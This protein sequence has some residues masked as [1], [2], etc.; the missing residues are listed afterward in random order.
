MNVY[1]FDDTIYD[2]DSTV[3]FYR[4]ALRRHPGLLRYL[5][6]QLWGILRYKLGCGTKERM[7]EAFYAFLRGIP[8]IDEEIRAFWEIHRGNIKLWYLAQKR[9]DDLIIS[10]SPAFLLRPICRELGVSLLASRVDAHTGAYTGKNCRGEEK[11]RRYREAY[12]DAPIEA[13]YSDSDTSPHLPS[14]PI[15]SRAARSRNGDRVWIENRESSMS[16]SVH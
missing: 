2:G 10:A 9:E 8:A 13:F 11:V 1:D 15:K 16:Y 6:R 5:P 4:F 3:D 7:K 14:M 12:G